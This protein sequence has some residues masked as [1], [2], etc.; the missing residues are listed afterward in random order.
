MQVSLG[1][2]PKSEISHK[3]M[4]EIVEHFQQY[5]P[6]KME[7]GKLTIPGV[8]ER[9][10]HALFGGDLLT[11]KRAQ[12]SQYTRRNSLC[13]K[14]RL[15]GFKPVVEDWHAKMCLLGVSFY[16]AHNIQ[17]SV[18]LSIHLSCQL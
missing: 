10:V 3:G 15:E 4:I 12:G 5:V 7:T 18:L 14:D 11:A 13:G 8:G 17:Y 2:L 9:E 16:W 1:I 6:L